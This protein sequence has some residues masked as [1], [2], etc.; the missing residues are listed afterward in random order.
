MGRY[1]VR[2]LKRHPLGWLRIM[3]FP[4]LMAGLLLAKAFIVAEPVFDVTS[5]A[6]AWPILL[7]LLAGVLAASTF[8]PLEPRMQAGSA[9]TMFAVAVLRV[10]TYLHTLLIA[11]EALGQ[12]GRVVVLGFMVNWVVI[13]A[14]AAWWPTILEESGRRMTLEAGRDDRDGS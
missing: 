1:E 3:W 14:V 7:A 9:A 4:W 12:N 6:P 11:G 10:L 13:A 2:W 5:V 8:A